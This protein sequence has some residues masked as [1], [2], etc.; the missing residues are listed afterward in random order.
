MPASVVNYIAGLVQSVG[1]WDYIWTAAISII[2]YYMG[3]ALIYMG[4]FSKFAVWLFVGGFV[5]VAFWI[6]SYLVNRRMQR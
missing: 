1:S 2:P 4:I 3:A 5:V 6:T